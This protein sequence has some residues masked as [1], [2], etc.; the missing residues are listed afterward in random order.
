MTKRVLI[1]G[2]S[3][4]LGQTL[5]RILSERPELEV[6]GTIRGARPD[7]RENQDRRTGR[8]IGGV[9]AENLDTV[10]SA[11]A[12]TGADV[13]I[14]CI[15][16]IK[17]VSAA[18]EPLAVIPINALLPHRLAELCR[19]A[20]TRL[21]HFS[22]DCVFSGNRGNY[23]ESDVPDATDLYGRTKLIG[24]VTQPHTLTIRT[25]I[26]G[27]E[28]QSSVSLIDW[29][30]SQN[31]PVK[32]YSAAIY[33]G[34]PTVEM[35]RILAQIVIPNSAL[36]GLYHVSSKPISKLELLKLV[37]RQY[38]KTIEIVPDNEVKIDRSLNSTRFTAV[39]GY[40]APSW[41]ELIA[42]MHRDYMIS[43]H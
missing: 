28:L 17:Q 2:I 40:V 23:I 43:V 39:T 11:I 41:N 15:G 21:I 31:G 6:T 22:T 10:T 18:S 30:L 20:R 12:E 4:M 19:A 27:H 42:Q 25:S 13:L 33:S 14:N 8:I 34:F 16:V 29:F 35:A 7:N 36:N 3:G 1:L 37:A 26:I 32:G 9:T 5:F 38:R 24:E